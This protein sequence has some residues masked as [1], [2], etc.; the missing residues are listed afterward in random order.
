M[1][2]SF[3]RTLDLIDADADTH[4]RANEVLAAIAWAGKLLKNVDLLVAGSYCLAFVDI[5]DNSE[6]G[7]QVLASVRHILKSLAIH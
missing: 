5:D 7:K 3:T 4:A 6:E 2:L 1:A